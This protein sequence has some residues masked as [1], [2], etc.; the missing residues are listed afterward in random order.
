MI[1]QVNKCAREGERKGRRRECRIRSTGA[2]LEMEESVGTH[3]EAVPS[4][5]QVRGPS[6]RPGDN[7][8]ERRWPHLGAGA[9]GKCR[10][11]E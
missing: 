1:I 11:R 8:T 9:G 2:R 6:D 7:R 10:V 3:R 4:L 5:A